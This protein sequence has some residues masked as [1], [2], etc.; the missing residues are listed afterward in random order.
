MDDARLLT[1]SC[2]TG[3]LALTH[4]E[5]WLTDTALVRIPLSPERTPGRPRGERKRGFDPTVRVVKPV[6]APPELAPDQARA[7]DRHH[8]YVPLDG[9]RSARLHHGRLSDRLA[10][11]MRTGERHKLLWLSA[12]PAYGVLR[13]AL[14]ASLG[15]RFALD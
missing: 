12:D 1:R 2:T 5:L 7:G 10:I 11:S 9:V 6:P 8:R 4:G 3:W 15:D 13:T 14:A